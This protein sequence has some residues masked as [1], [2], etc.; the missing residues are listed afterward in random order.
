MA[1]D[2]PPTIVTR[3]YGDDPIWS[4]VVT[5]H[6][7]VQEGYSPAIIDAPF[8][9]TQTST[10]DTTRAHFRV[11]TNA[12]LHPVRFRFR[13]GCTVGSGTIKCVV[14]AASTDQ[15]V[16]GAQSWYTVD[17]TP[18]VA[19]P[20]CELLAKVT[21]GGHSLEVTALQ[22]YLAPAAGSDVTGWVDVDETVWATTDSP[23]PSRVVEDLLNGVVL[24]AR[25]R[26]F[27]IFSRVAD[28][29][30]TVSGK[31]VEAWGVDNSDAWQVAG[32]AFLGQRNNLAPRGTC[33]LDAYVT[34]TGTADISIAVGAA[35]WEFTASSDGWYT[36]TIQLDTGAPIVVSAAPGASD[37]VAVR[38]L[39]IWRGG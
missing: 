25:D 20:D 27:C 34:R 4:T 1:Y 22:V 28:V 13:A 7:E 12:A 30:A 14:G 21:S 39:Q 35:R 38:T 2:P 17:V 32:R 37:E 8:R 33:R 15:A 18:L 31:T 19:D 11:R 24:V 16:T 5:N 10:S 23:I 6:G 3:L 9:I 26:P 36:S 29:Q